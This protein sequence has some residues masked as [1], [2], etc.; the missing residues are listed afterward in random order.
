MLDLAFRY[1]SRG[2]IRSYSTVEV[3]KPEDRAGGRRQ[4]L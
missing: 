2:D 3:Q 1:F 4:A